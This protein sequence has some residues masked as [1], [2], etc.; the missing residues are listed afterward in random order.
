MV[1]SNSPPSPGPTL[2]PPSSQSFLI[3]PDLS[4]THSSNLQPPSP[5]QSS[6]ASRSDHSRQFSNASSVTYPR[7]SP[8]PMTAFSP[9]SSNLGQST[10]VP[11]GRA[12]VNTLP[13]WAKSHD[14]DDELFEIP[15]IRST[16]NPTPT[17]QTFVS[18][19]G[20]SMSRLSRPSLSTT[21]VP[22]SLHHVLPNPPRSC[23]SSSDC[24]EQPPLPQ[25]L[26][27]RVAS[28]QL[29]RK[30]KE[31]SWPKSGTEAAG[32]E[33]TELDSPAQRPRPQRAMSQD[34]VREL[35]FYAMAPARIASSIDLSPVFQRFKSYGAQRKRRTEEGAI[36][37][38]D[39][40]PDPDP[41]PNPDLGPE[42]D[43]A[44]VHGTDDRWWQFT[45][46]SK[47]R[48][49]VELYIQRGGPHI[50]GVGAG[51]WNAV[52]PSP[53]SASPRPFEHASPRVL[54]G[55][56]QGLTSWHPTGHPFSDQFSDYRQHQGDFPLS[57]FSR[58]MSVS[59]VQ[60]GSETR[61]EAAEPRKGLATYLLHHPAAPLAFRVANFVTISGS[62]AISVKIRRIEAKIGAIGAVG[63]STL[64]ILIIAPISLVHIL[65]SIY[66]EYFGAPIGIWSVSWKMFHTL[67]ELVSIS[68][69]SS[70][71]ALAFD[72]GLTSE[73][74]CSVSGLKLCELQAGLVCTIFLGLATYTLVLVVS[75]LRIFNKVSR[76]A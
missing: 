16:A 6:T 30:G 38:L 19:S 76:K 14:D 11:S 51:G 8:S 74:G 46:R 63:N 5:C 60:E 53:S 75:L 45:L 4:Y 3:H 33:M 32:V 47:Y 67:S 40:D 72:N 71:L 27:L 12:K 65:F 28:V 22:D 69:W 13:P 44:R 57:A 20:S 17:A 59:F 64:F 50:G 58:K 26:K 9:S 48:K 1:L 2:R 61:P 34:A 15:T 39:L 62:L 66:C 25:R 54:E 43:H 24:D 55:V 35:P 68:L 41:N 49:K 18:P 56:S 10:I 29:L 21:L 36:R 37:E 42:E 52:A 7:N 73:L 23:S 70:A 31:K